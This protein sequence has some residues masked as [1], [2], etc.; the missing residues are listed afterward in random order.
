MY[1]CMLLGFITTLQ[2]LTLRYRIDLLHNSCSQKL[3]QLN[4]LNS[5][6]RFDRFLHSFSVYRRLMKNLLLWYCRG[7][8][9]I[10]IIIVTVDRISTEWGL[11]VW[12]EFRLTIMRVVHTTYS[13]LFCTTIIIIILYGRWNGAWKSLIRFSVAFIYCARHGE[14]SPSRS[15]TSDAPRPYYLRNANVYTSAVKKKINLNRSESRALHPSAQSVEFVS[16]GTIANSST[17]NKNYCIWLLEESDSSLICVKFGRDSLF[18]IV[19]FSLFWF[20]FFSRLQTERVN[21]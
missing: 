12:Q 11:W 19:L 17:L 8:E 20:C 9:I 4:I 7:K 18:Y 15:D 10:Y 5:I 2:A 1:I 6:T 3:S 13:P 16:R 14:I 21:V